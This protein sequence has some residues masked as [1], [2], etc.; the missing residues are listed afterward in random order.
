MSDQSKQ[1]TAA[2]DFNLT[3]T[4]ISPI[5]GHA[6]RING[7][8]TVQ[9][10]MVPLSFLDLKEDD[11]R[12]PGPYFR[13][14]VIGDR[15]GSSQI[16][17]DLSFTTDL[18]FASS[19]ICLQ[20][21]FDGVEEKGIET[22]AQGRAL[23]LWATHVAYDFAALVIRQLVSNHPTINDIDLPIKPLTPEIQVRIKSTEANS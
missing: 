12:E 16:F 1:Q 10:S 3:P 2:D 9:A 14:L 5:I 19:T 8:H 18:V 6:P 22:E 4:D 20:V 15:E 23:A 11:K 7:N 21:E 13:L 17:A